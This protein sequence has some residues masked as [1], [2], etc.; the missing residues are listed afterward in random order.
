MAKASGRPTA[1]LGS[2]LGTDAARWKASGGGCWPDGQDRSRSQ[3]SDEAGWR[4]CW[5]DA[6]DLRR[7][8]GSPADIIRKIFRGRWL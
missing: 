7:G 5:P 6:D 3:G 8:D 1:N 2:L 4:G